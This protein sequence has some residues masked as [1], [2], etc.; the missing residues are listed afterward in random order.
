MQLLNTLLL[1][2]RTIGFFSL[3]VKGLTIN[4]EYTHLAS[5]ITPQ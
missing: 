2:I 5:F 3:P 4:D 1:I